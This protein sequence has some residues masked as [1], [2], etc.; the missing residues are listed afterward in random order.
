[1]FTA[2]RVPATS[3]GGGFGDARGLARNRDRQDA[4]NEPAD[5]GIERNRLAE[6]DEMALAI[7]LRLRAADG[8]HAVVEAGMPAG[9]ERRLQREH[10][11]QHVA[12]ARRHGIEQLHHDA[13]RHLV[14]EHRKRA[15]RQHDEPAAALPNESRVELERLAAKSGLNLSSCV[16]LPWT[17]ETATGGPE[18][19]VHS[20]RASAAPPTETIATTPPA[21]AILMH[22][23]WASASIATASAAARTAVASVTRNT[24]PNGA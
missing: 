16:T 7:E 22:A 17:S 12:V 11:G 23:E 14:R 6:R 2:T 18:G 1:M 8:D 19:A 24:P 13:L 5:D 15:L 9:R 20:M 4:A 10:S 3:S 21:T